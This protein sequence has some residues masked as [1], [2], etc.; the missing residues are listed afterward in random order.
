LK[1]LVKRLGSG[2]RAQDWKDLFVAWAPSKHLSLTLAYV[3]LGTIVP[4]TTQQRRQTGTYFSAQA[5]F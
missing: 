1:S 4:A 2:L 3:D 5:A